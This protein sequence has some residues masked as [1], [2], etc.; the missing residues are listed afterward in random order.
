MRNIK[1]VCFFLSLMLVLSGCSIVIQKGRRSDMERIESLEKEL[2][3]L[4][5]SK[6]LIEKRLS[7]EIDSDQIRL[8][9]QDKGL[10][11]TFVAEVLFSSGKAELKKDSYEMLNKVVKILNEDVPE[12]NI[13][14]E[15]HTDNVPITKSHWK[16]NWELSSQRAL[17]VLA[18]LEQ[19]G[20]SAARLSAVGY[21]EHQPVASNDDSQGRKL[22]RRVEVVVLPKIERKSD[23][24]VDQGVSENKNEEYGEELK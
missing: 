17:S 7:K 24:K 18:Y 9:M 10:V 23:K 2:A 22:N 3:D 15:G 13:A 20:V 11:I 14:I 16:S 1:L 4:R 12:Y 8:S 6:D 19:N 21:G 5:S